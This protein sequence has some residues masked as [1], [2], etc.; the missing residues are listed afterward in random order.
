MHHQL[1]HFYEISLIYA[2]TNCSP[3]F[4]VRYLFELTDDFFFNSKKVIIFFTN[5]FLSMNSYS[6]DFD[7]HKI[8]K[9]K[10][11]NVFASLESDVRG[12]FEVYSHVDPG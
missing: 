4:E 10:F 11:T 9:L 5:S 1:S 12:C 8:Y 3:S 2:N 7:G 6:N